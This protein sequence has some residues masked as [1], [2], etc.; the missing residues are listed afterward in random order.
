MRQPVVS[1]V[2][3]APRV[4]LLGVERLHDFQPGQTVKIGLDDQQPPR[5]YSICSGNRDAELKVLYNIKD[6]GELTPQLAQLKPGDLIDISKPCGSFIG[7]KDP[8]MWIATGTGIAP[9]YS[10]FRSGLGENKILLHGVRYAEQFYFS[11]E[12][13]ST[14]Q[15]RYRPICSGEQVDGIPV[16]RV[17]RLLEQAVLPPKWKYYLCGQATMCVEIRDLLI[18]RDIPFGNIITE[19]YF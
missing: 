15:D 17:N 9:F 13:K 6:D 14:F 19:I 11:D 8:A 2:E 5:F 10:M 16:G 18:S 4:F 1:H 7:T 12:W 3:I